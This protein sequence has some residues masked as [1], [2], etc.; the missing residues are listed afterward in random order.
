MKFFT[1]CFLSALTSLSLYSQEL[2]QTIRGTVMEK[3]SRSGIPGASVSLLDDASKQ[4]VTTT[5]A[6]GNFRLENVSLGRHTL[7]INYIGYYP[8]ILQN[9][10]VDKGKESIINVEL[11]EAVT[12][13]EEVN[14]TSSDKG[15]ANND[16]STVSN[17][18]FS[19][20]EANRYAGS[21]GD[22]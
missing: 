17:K 13:M 1:F 2:T 12:K 6:K 15:N 11:E 21:R 14:V 19:M 8:V 7:K 5:D 4:N 16:M 22:P 3:E 20:E 18:N 9:I 10:I